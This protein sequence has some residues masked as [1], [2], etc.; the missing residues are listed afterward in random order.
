MEHKLK[1]KLILKSEPK[2]ISD[3]FR[4]MDFVIQTPDEKYPQSIQFQ[5]LNDRIQEM[6]KFTTKFTEQ[7][8]KV[9]KLFV[10]YNMNDQA[11]KLSA[12]PQFTTDVAAAAEEAIRAA[13]PKTTFGGSKKY[14]KKIT[15]NMSNGRKQKAK[16]AKA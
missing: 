6:D 2:Q 3:K 8:E 12:V 16:R 15:I 4:V 14:L 13:P 11:A 1:G 9:K 7:A 10:S 5:L